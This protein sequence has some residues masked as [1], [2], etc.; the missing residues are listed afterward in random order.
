MRIQLSS[1]LRKN[2]FLV[3]AAALL[4]SAWLFCLQAFLEQWLQ[5]KADLKDLERA[6]RVQP[7]NAETEGRIGLRLLQPPFDDY[8]AA[9]HHLLKSVALNPHDSL[10]WQKLADTYELLGDAARQNDAV[11]HALAAEPKDTQVLWEAANLSINTDLDGSLQ[12]LRS[13]IQHSEQYASAAIEVA[14][15]ASG[16]D[17]EKTMLAVPATTT[18]RLYLIKWL[19]DRNQ[20]EAADRVWPTV[21]TSEGDIHPRDTFFY[22]DSLID[23]HEVK[24]ARMVWSGLLQKN[25]GLE[26]TSSPRSLVTNGDFEGELL[27]GAFGWRY[28]PTA[29]VTATLD[30]STF[31]SGTRSL[32]LQ[33]DGENLA[34]CGLTQLVPVE[35]GTR[36]RLSAWVHGEEL[37]AAHGVRISVSDLYSHADL[38]VTDE[39][40]GSFPWRDVA[41]EFEVPQATDLVKIAFVRSPSVGIIRGRLWVD[42]VR[43]EKQ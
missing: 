26:A 41:G 14:Y 20:T 37:E 15:S 36:Y 5:R 34:D 19:L 13:V 3:A 32:A 6:A 39:A 29:G 2:T 40:V 33:I 8:S 35:P 25:P 4:F 38:L 28:I 42:D 7:L 31:R 10:A 22:F 17:I 9:E 24:Q 43:I 23:R 21:L 12:L 27:N 1:Q 18:S 30:T 16:H 11:Q